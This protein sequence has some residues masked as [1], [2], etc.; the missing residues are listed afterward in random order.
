MNILVSGCLL[1]LSCRYD[2]ERKVYPELNNIPEKINLIPVCPEQLGG[3]STPRP[4]SEKKG[5][6]VYNIKGEDVT[7]N[8]ERGA[9]EALYLA[10]KFNCEIAFL[11]EKSPSCGKGE[12]YSGDFSGTLIKGDG[13]LGKLLSEKGI[14]VIGESGIEDFLKELKK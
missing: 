3:L 5:D 4:K 11:K 2:G 1:G 14:R 12:I 9:K 6:K 10:E 7:E 13:V 8:F